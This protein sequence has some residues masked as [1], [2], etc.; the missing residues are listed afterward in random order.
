VSRFVKEVGHKRRREQFHERLF[1]VR[2]HRRERQA[3][4]TD[5]DARLLAAR[6]G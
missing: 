6:A 4:L 2:R 5:D 3:A 1:G